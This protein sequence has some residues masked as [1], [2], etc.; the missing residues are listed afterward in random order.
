MRPFPFRGATLRNS[1]A[2][3][4]CD[5]PGLGVRLLQPDFEY[6]GS[7]GGTGL[8]QVAVH[9]AFTSSTGQSLIGRRPYFTKERAGN[10]E[11]H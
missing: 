5:P 9:F 11:H 8:N 3:S 10:E 2:C 4:V 1:G 7:A 6:S